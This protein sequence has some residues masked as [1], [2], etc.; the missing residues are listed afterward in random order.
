M[1][2]PGCVCCSGAVELAPPHALTHQQLTM[3]DS[4]D[5]DQD[6]VFIV[7]AST[8]PPQVLRAGGL[9]LGEALAAGRWTNGELRLGLN[10]IRST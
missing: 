2:A 1:G 4:N 9:V 5:E 8:A 3:A 10:A 6:D 7:G